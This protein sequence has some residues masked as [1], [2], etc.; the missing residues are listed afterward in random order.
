MQRRRPVVVLFSVLLLLAFGAAPAVADPDGQHGTDEGHLIGEG[1][2]GKIELLDVVVQFG[3]GELGHARPSGHSSY[4]IRAFG[5]RWIV[6]TA[7]KRGS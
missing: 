2:W 7:G 1:E 6:A 3:V 5:L 4:S